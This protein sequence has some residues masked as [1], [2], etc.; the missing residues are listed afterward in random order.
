[1]LLKTDICVYYDYSDDTSVWVGYTFKEDVSHYQ[2]AF[3]VCS[4]IHQTENY[5]HCEPVIEFPTA[6][7]VKLLNDFQFSWKNF[8]I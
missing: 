1:M 3:L 4:K 2:A 6:E 7:L 8:K 5:Y